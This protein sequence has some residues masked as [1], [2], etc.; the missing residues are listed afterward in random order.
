MVAAIRERAP[1]AERVVLESGTLSTGR[2]HGLRAL[3]V[4]VVC[5]DA[6]QTMTV[7]PCSFGP[8]E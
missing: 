7:I 1:E 3:E 2:W 8:W 5:V 4:P 6:R